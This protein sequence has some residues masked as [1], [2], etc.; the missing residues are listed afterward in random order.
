LQVEQAHQK[1]G[2]LQYL[3]LFQNLIVEL[4]IR[5]RNNAYVPLGTRHHSYRYR[6]LDIFLPAVLPVA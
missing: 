2:L 3:Y 6:N 1:T 5:N 4:D